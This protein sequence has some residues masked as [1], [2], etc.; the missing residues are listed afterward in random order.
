MVNVML[1]RERFEPFQR[2][3]KALKRDAYKNVE[4]LIG[5]LSYLFDDILEFEEYVS[6]FI[7]LVTNS[8]RRIPPRCSMPFMFEKLIMKHFNDFSVEK[9]LTEGDIDVEKS[10]T[11][12]RKECMKHWREISRDD[13]NSVNARLTEMMYY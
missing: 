12:F 1:G 6:W 9:F 2:G 8:W 4:E 5:V 13:V 11:E 10:L 3:A 7:H